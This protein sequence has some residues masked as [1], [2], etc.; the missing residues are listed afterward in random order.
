MGLAD[1]GRLATAD[2]L[3]TD[4]GISAEARRVL[5]D[6]VGTLIVVPVADG[7]LGRAFAGQTR[8]RESEL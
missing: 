5:E 4:D 6:Q 3:I 8:Q 1:F 7:T 2:V